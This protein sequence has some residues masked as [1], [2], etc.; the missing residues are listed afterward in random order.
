MPNL[1]LQDWKRDFRTA[2]RADRYDIF[3]DHMR[4]LGLPGKPS[5]MM[6]AT[7]LMVQASAAYYKIDGRSCDGFFAMQKY[8]PAKSPG[9]H[10]F[11]FDLH[12]KAY[13]RLLVDPETHIIDLADLYGHPWEPYQTAG[14]SQI[15]ISHTHWTD[16]TEKEMEVLEEQVTDDLRFDYEEDELD[17]WFDDSNAKYLCVYVQDHCEPDDENEE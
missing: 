1:T 10:A 17:F 4:F 5:S 2:A 8:N 11:T 13:A 14:Y 16:I 15:W 7:I 6:K 9:R 3:R 12:G